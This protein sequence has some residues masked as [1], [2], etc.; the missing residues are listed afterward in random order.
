MSKDCDQVPCFRENPLFKT[1]LDQGSENKKQS[2][3]WEPV[4]NTPQPRVG[5]R[6]REQFTEGRTQHPQETHVVGGPAGAVTGTVVSR[7][8]SVAMS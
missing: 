4:V 3:S 1:E 8:V 7:A 6:F 5:G 2:R